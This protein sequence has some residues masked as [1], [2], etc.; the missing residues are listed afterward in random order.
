M[1]L[2]NDVTGIIYSVQN[3]ITG[4]YYIGATTHTLEERMP[5]LF[6]RRF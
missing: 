5:F 3:V 2:E 1:E 6:F 4:E